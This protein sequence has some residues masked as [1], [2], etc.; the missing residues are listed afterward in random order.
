MGRISGITFFLGLLIELTIVIL[1]KS[2]YTIQYE[3][4]WFR[5][6]FLLF[7][8]SL[9]TTRH[10]LKEW[11]G[12]FLLAI[13]GLISYRATGRN[14]ILRCLVFIWACV[15]KDMRKTMKFTFWYTTA[16]CGMLILLSILGIAG[17][18][19][20]TAVYRYD[21]VEHRYCFGM[22]HPNAFHCMMLA[23]T[24]L[25]MYCYYEKIRWW[26]YGGITIFHLIVF[27]LTKSR[28]SFMV[29]MGA[30]LLVVLLRY[31]KF[32][33]KWAGSYLLG[34]LI[35]AGAVWF[36]V[37]MARFGVSNPFL[38]K[39]DPYLSGR[40]STLNWDSLNQEGM[41]HTWSLWSVARNN[42]FFDLGIVRVFYWFGIIPGAVYF[43]AQCR[44]IWC[45]YRAKD[46][47][48]LA[49]MISITIYTVFEAHYVSD[50][51]GRNY[52]FF[53]MGMYLTRMLGVKKKEETSNGQ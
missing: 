43:L 4:Q 12:L 46:F 49:V 42:Y 36:S 27:F 44:L 39:L 35:I 17:Q 29:S 33:Q 52:I 22:G 11:V 31:C 13:L 50:Y 30:I 8:I 51:I 23:I 18:V 26:G 2:A 25:G 20:Q 10:S 1:D 14:E 5:V 53:F 32:L 34:I 45:G 6:T 37:F 28:S 40:I 7:G 38:Y 24:L 3:G 21:I 19:A 47:L 9:I 41:L 16:G 48:L 15:G